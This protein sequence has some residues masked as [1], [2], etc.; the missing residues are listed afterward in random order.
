MPV[1]ISIGRVIGDIVVLVVC[2]VP[3]LFFHKWVK[4]Y[5]RG[6]YCDD[7]S[8]RYPYLPSTVSRQM[9][10]FIG[11]VLPIILIILTETY[12]TLRWE[13]KCKNQF[14]VY[15]C[16]S[17]TINRFVVRL[18]VFLGYFFL[19]VCFNQLM[20]DVSKYTIGRHRPHFMSICQPNVGWKSC[21]S[22]HTYITQF[23]CN[24]TEKRLIH[25]SM[26]SFY[27][28]HASFSF[29]VAAYISLYLR[30]RLYRPIFSQLIIP[31]IQ[32]FL[33][34]GAAFVAFSR[35]SD[36]KHHWSD[37]LVGSIAGTSIGFINALYIAEV[38]KRREIPAAHDSA[39]QFGLIPLDARAVASIEE[40]VGVGVPIGSS[41][42]GPN[43]F[44]SRA[45]VMNNDVERGNNME[46][47][48]KSPATTESKTSRQSSQENND[49][50]N[51]GSY[52]NEIY[53]DPEI[54]FPIKNKKK[55][56]LIE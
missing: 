44:A 12:R 13:R 39:C 52:R 10:I 1:N 50:Q 34:F 35:I 28:G 45:I 18:Y 49:H 30:A 55:G 4:P 20:V 54:V 19:G 37:V 43:V 51:N 40:G 7:E 17:R 21:P 42:K 22:D 31:A 24:G 25:E 32:F 23:E 56:I 15:Q 11:L 14:K 53:L 5:K 38:F 6:F 47:H 36:Y 41:S 46:M 9:L 8:I 2:A 16:G 27:S 33:F 26:L 29:Y 48:N 3:M